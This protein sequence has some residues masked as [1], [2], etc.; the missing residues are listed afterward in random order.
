MSS[1]I[2]CR[3]KVAMTGKMDV[4][5]FMLADSSARR[6]PSCRKNLFFFE[7]YILRI[8]VSIIIRDGGVV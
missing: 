1:L 6:L 4:L 8:H 2:V 5:W 7:G 3:L